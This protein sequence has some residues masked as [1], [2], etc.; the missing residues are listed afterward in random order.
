V[1]RGWGWGAQAGTPMFLLARKIKAMGVKM[2]LSG[3]GADEELGGYLYFHK[4]PD[5]DEFHEECVR[6][7]KAL[8]QF[9]CLRANKSTHAWGLEARCPFLDKELV[10]HSMEDFGADAKMCVD[11]RDGHGR[12]EKWLIRSAFD[13]PDDPYLPSEVLW[14]QKEQFS[15]GVGYSWI[16]G[17]KDHAESVVS[18]KAMAAAPMVFEENPPLTKEAYLYRSIFESHF[19]Q[20]S[21]RRSVPGGPSVAC[22]T[23]AAIKWDASFALAATQDPSGR[24]VAGVHADAYQGQGGAGPAKKART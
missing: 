15:D 11:R 16:D 14:R 4:C 22:S 5:A 10:W 1:T 3:E 8:H 24:S 7:V 19:P 20:A 18:D 21:A 17:L 12:I 23:A 2:V 13:T 9:D 6:K